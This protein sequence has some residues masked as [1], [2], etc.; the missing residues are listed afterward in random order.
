MARG[1]WRASWLAVLVAVGCGGEV[2]DTNPNGNG[3]MPGA[4]GVPITAGSSGDGNASEPGSCVHGESLQCACDD[5]T[6]GWQQ[7]S[8]DGDELGP[9]LCSPPSKGPPPSEDCSACLERACSRWRNEC[10]AEPAC[11][12]AFDCIDRTGCGTRGTCLI[13]CPV[14]NDN[15]GPTGKVGNLVSNVTACSETSRCPC[16]GR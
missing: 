11:E 2:I 8:P 5:G 12:E 15:G 13:E 3:G 9:C 14:I 10:R 6:S 16:F 1:D 4:G 7:C